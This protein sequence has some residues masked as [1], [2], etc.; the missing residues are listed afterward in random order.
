MIPPGP[1]GPFLFRKLGQ[2]QKE[3]RVLQSFWSFSAS[4]SQ[5][6]PMLLEDSKVKEEKFVLRKKG[7]ACYNIGRTKGTHV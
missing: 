5:C 6:L 2:F 3:K 1:I 4:P 7:I